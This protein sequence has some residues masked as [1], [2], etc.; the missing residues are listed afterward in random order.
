MNLKQLEYF[1]AVARLRS[2]TAAAAELGIAQPTLTKSIRSLEQELGVKLFQRLA[3]GVEPT[4]VGLSLVRHAESI[5]VQVQDALAE[6]GSL[7]GGAVGTVKI[8]AGPAWLRRHLPLAVARTVARNPGIR[9]RIEG[10]FDD[11]LL[12]ALRRGEVDFAVAE[13]PSVETSQDL[14]ILP[15]TS[16]RLGAC[17]RAGHPLHAAPEPPQLFHL[18]GYPWVMPPRATRAQRRLRALFVAAD[19]QPPEALVET[20][21]MAFLIQMV[22]HS[23]ALT[24]TVST[25]LQAR[26]SEGLVMLE[27]PALAATRQAGVVSRK[28]G[29]LSPA[30]LAV[31]DEL[32]AICSAEP[33]N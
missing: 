17:C 33:T 4:D 8:G 30:A 7:S 28:D 21:S 11:A 27:V 32:R 2:M 22:R 10:G 14:N 15:L 19:L 16:D 6:I 23:D 20:E 13:L 18:L 29:W 5:S 1:L 26:E 25:T 9:V 3:R 12:R 31:V 24:F